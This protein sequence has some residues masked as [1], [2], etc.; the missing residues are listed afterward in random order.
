LWQLLFKGGSDSPPDLFTDPVDFTQVAR[1]SSARHK[2]GKLEFSL[3]G[4]MNRN[5]RTSLIS[6]TLATALVLGF[7]GTAFSR[8]QAFDKLKTLVG[9]WEAATPKGK[10]TATFE[11]AS[12]G[13]AL[14]EHLSMTSGE[15]MVTV[16]YVDGNRLLL[17]HYCEGGNQPRMQATTFD[18]N[19]DVISFHFVDGTNVQT[20]GTMFMHDLSIEF[21]GTSE[22]AADWTSF[23]D[24][25]TSFTV[26]FVYHRVN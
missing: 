15:D 16:Y 7:V 24:G 21:H 2:R 19:S 26:P 3:E 14:L 18:P 25:K 20:P 11:L 1:R 22:V 5:H 17:T 13:T 9:T 12:K 4:K 23:K 6:L 8:T 10:A